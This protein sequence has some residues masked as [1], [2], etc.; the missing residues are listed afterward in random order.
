MPF[1]I[2]LTFY[3][4]FNDLELMFFF[5]FNNSIL[6]HFHESSSAL[7]QS[8]QLNAQQSSS[9]NYYGYEEIDVV[10]TWV[11]GSDPA[12]IEQIKRYT[13]HYDAARF[14]DKNELKYSLRFNTLPFC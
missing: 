9:S 3:K 13:Q 12:F 8:L 6:K 11:N 4:R 5:F 10:Y 7:P 14:D 2:L 1:N